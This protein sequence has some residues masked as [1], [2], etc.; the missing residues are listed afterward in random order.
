MFIFQ[1]YI[2]NY[3]YIII[4]NKYIYIICIY[5]S[6]RTR[7]HNVWPAGLWAIVLNPWLKK[8]HVKTAWL[9]NQQSHGSMPCDGS[10]TGTSAKSWPSAM[11]WQ[12]DYQ[13]SKV[14]GQ[15]LVSKTVGF[16]TCRSLQN[17]KTL[18][19]PQ[20]PEQREQQII[21]KAS[22][23]LI[24]MSVRLEVQDSEVIDL[25]DTVVFGRDHNERSWSSTFRKF[26]FNLVSNIL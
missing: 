22:Y 6:Q 20:D 2:Y 23:A 11:S 14:M 24:W 12:L 19:V 7:A 18:D 1:H 5:F 21:V 13:I 17:L 4:V 3:I 10:L 8:S 16:E 9:S 15:C 25:F 26:W